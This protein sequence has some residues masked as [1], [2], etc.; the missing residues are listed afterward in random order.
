MEYTIQEVARAAGTSSRTL[1]H[2]NK[3]GLLSPSRVGQNGYRFYDDRALVR[4]Q[5]VLLLRGLGLGLDAIAEV[6]SAQDRETGRTESAPAAEARVLTGHLEI[7]RAEAVSLT[8][9][10][11]AVE[12]TIAA[13]HEAAPNAGGDKA[14]SAHHTTQKEGLMAH[15]IF[16]GFDHTQHR[17][18]V[19][20]RWG[21]E[22]YAAGAAWWEGLD[23]TEQ[24]SW[25]QRSAQLAAAWIDAAQSGVAPES[26]AA[27]QLA[28][29][30]VA[31]LK[32]VPG[33]PAANDGESDQL[34]G[35]VLGL[36]EMYVADE[37]FAANYGG[38][39]G[40]EFVRDALTTYVASGT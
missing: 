2:Y 12:R 9:R 18:E 24:Q 27:Q 28:A 20:T 29:Q 8:A 3:I 39:A 16:D 1:R 40:A 7:L 6:L 10:I 34:A 35:Y 22:A 5:R 17:D 4:L 19:E 13:L 31:W 23:M 11:A 26:P 33:T 30:H 32:S 25:Q 36:A 14:A 15:N 21:K 37:R 38:L